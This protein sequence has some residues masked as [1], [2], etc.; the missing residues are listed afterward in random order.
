MADVHAPAFLLEA[1]RTG[2]L[3]L[4]GFTASPTEMRPL[5]EFLHRSGF[6]VLGVRLEGHGTNPGDLARTGWQDWLAS[7]ATGL[8]ELEQRCD[9][10][11]AAGLSMGGVL[12][13]V[14]AERSPGRL[15]A[16]CLLA[17]AF[18]LRSPF[19]P[20][21]CFLRPVL[22][23]IGKGSRVRAYLAERGLFSYPVMPVPALVQL[24]HLMRLG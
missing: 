21:A 1:G 2:V 7:A 3:L 14:L 19:L 11:F 10:V 13:A 20:L 23:S 6:T 8:W 18:R 9:L 17:P 24:H 15:R 22:R 12:A 16:L 5:G 4:H